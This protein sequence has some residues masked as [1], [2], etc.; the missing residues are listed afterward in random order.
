MQT[1][2]AGCLAD[3]L[4]PLGLW[5]WHAQVVDFNM[6][7]HSL[8]AR[9]RSAIHDVSLSKRSLFSALKSPR[10]CAEKGGGHACEQEGQSAAGT[11]QKHR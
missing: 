1:F 3:P 9:D 2:D 11:Q 6:P 7:R 5:A 10:H 4:P 8:L